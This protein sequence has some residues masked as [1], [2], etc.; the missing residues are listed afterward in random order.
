M[1]RVLRERPNFFI[2]PDLPQIPLEW[3]LC[4][5][6]GGTKRLRR[7]DG[8]GTSETCGRCHGAGIV[9]LPKA[10]WIRRGWVHSRS[11]RKGSHEENLRRARKELDIRLGDAYPPGDFREGIRLDCLRAGIGAPAFSQSPE[12]IRDQWNNWYYGDPRRVISRWST[13]PIA[14]NGATYEWS[15]SRG[16]LTIGSATYKRYLRAERFLEQGIRIAFNLRPSPNCAYPLTSPNP[17]TRRL[18]LVA[19]LYVFRD[20]LERPWGLR[21]QCSYAKLAARYKCTVEEVRGS[22]SR[23]SRALRAGGLLP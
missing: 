19:V 9:L 18:A 13:G 10:E 7:L 5:P 8:S 12:E 22:V 20:F 6:C 3:G 2:D 15:I 4:P 23:L 21:E 1:R 14:L 17:R 11:P 16:P